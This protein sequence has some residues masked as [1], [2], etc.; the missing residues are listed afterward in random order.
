MLTERIHDVDLMAFGGK[1]EHFCKNQN[2]KL[3]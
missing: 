1:N 3:F 2:R